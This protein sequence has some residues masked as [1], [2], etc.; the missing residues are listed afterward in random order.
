MKFPKTPN[1]K[2]QKLIKWLN[3]Q[4][5]YCDSVPINYDNLE[6]K[7]TEIDTLSYDEIDQ[8]INI[9]DPNTNGYYCN[10]LYNKIIDDIIEKKLYLIIP[11]KTNNNVEYDEQNI[12]N[13]DCKKNFYNFCMNN[14][15]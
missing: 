12:L 13:I 14:S 3:K 5:E 8:H 15:L 6:T 1:N 4:N 11:I 10:E 7:D 9:T 2:R